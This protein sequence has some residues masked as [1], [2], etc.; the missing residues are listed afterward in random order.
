ML[1]LFAGGH[2]MG[3]TFQGLIGLH[4]LKQLGIKFR[5][6]DNP[7]LNIFHLQKIR[8]SLRAADANPQFYYYAKSHAA[9]P[10]QVDAVL[11]AENSRIYLVWRDQRDALVSDFYFSQRLAGHVY[12]DFQDYFWR[13][14]RKI[15]LRNRL[16]QVVWDGIKD[17]RVRAWDYLDLVNEFDRSAGEMLEFGSLEGVDMDALKKSVS[18]G[19]LRKTYNDPKGSFFRK[20]GKQN[21][22]ELAPDKRTLNEIEDIVEEADGRKLGKAYEREDWLRIVA[23]GRESK[24]AGLRKTFHWWLFRTQR[25]QWLRASVLPT[26]YK[27]SP[28]RLIGSLL[29]RNSQ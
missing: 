8:E 29:H 15:L 18:I 13:R 11:T 10:A 23:F 4:A 14:G 27:L 2:R 3:S 1:L 22:E 17:D 26:L 12:K 25:A 19:E 21:I 7:A 9:F 24:D 28:R 6:A 16:Q 20:G 5:Q